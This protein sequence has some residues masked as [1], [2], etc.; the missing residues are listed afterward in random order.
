[1]T[2]KHRKF[3]LNQ[4]AIRRTILSS[5]GR[6]GGIIH[7]GKAQNAQLPRKLQR[8]TKDYDIFVRRPNIRAVALEMKL[9]KLFRG[10]FFRVKRGKSKVIPVS[11]VISNVTT[12]STGKKL[13]FNVM[14]SPCLYQDLLVNESPIISPSKNPGSVTL[15]VILYNCPGIKSFILTHS[16]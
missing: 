8:P 5:V 15:S 9:D 2:D 7:G 1:M 16:P 12:S 4:P 3:E 13:P 11:K 10:D 6:K 14:L